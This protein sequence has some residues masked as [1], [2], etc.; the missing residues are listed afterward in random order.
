MGTLRGMLRFCRVQML[1]SGLSSPG[2]KT[3]NL[4]ASQKQ[5]REPCSPEPAPCTHWGTDWSILVLV[6]FPTVPLTGNLCV[7][8]GRAPCGFLLCSSRMQQTMPGEQ[9]GSTQE[10]SQ[11]VGSACTANMHHNSATSI[12]GKDTEVLF[13]LHQLFVINR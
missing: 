1:W 13:T 11:R 5:N 4:T 6:Y 3:H 12:H 7:Q 10:L 9:H 2:S 8:Q